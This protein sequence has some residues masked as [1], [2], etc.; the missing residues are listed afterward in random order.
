MPKNWHIG[1]NVLCM[2]FKK[3]IIES[4]HQFLKFKFLANFACFKKVF[5][6]ISFK[7]SC[8]HEFLLIMNCNALI[9][10]SISQ[11]IFLRF[12]TIFDS[13]EVIFIFLKIFYISKEISF[14]YF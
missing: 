11:E 12:E 8:Q 7:L 1:Q 4:K 14:L 9:L 5:V 10:I 13:Y 2:K 3:N 6:N